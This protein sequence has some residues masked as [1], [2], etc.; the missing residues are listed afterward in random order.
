MTDAPT[1]REERFFALVLPALER[2]GYTAYGAQAKLVADTGM[3]KTTVS[4]LLRG[5]TIPHVKSFPALARAL[6]LD[7]VELLVA[8]EIV[9]PEYLESQ[10][11]LSETDRSQVGSGSITPEEAAEQLGIHDDVGKFTFYAVVDKLTNRDD[12]DDATPGDATAQ[13]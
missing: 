1:G 3:N 8:A 13:A 4:R 12:A 9:P 6:G 5:E 11:T 10:Q 2:A 7:P